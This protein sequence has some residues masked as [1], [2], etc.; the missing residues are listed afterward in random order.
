MG[1]PEPP[2]MPMHRNRKERTEAA[3]QQT[4]VAFSTPPSRHRLVY[5]LLLAFAL[6]SFCFVY[7]D[8]LGA[9]LDALSLP[10]RFE[11]P[12]HDHRH[13]GH[14][15]G[16]KHKP[17]T[18]KKAEKVFLCVLLFLL[19]ISDVNPYSAALSLMKRVH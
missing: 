13:H 9:S 16:K 11:V 7:F 8:E 17:L 12:G 3:G 14:D 19:L 2:M 18:A 1:R 15:H 10:E 6:L 4:Q 5:R